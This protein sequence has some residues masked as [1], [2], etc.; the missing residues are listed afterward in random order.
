[1]AQCS[2]FNTATIVD[3]AVTTIV[4]YCIGYCLALCLLCIHILSVLH[5]VYTGYLLQRI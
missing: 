2:H 3:I 1:M 4:E 5:I